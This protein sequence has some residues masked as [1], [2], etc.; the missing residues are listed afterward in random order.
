MPATYN[1]NAIQSTTSTVLY[2]HCEAKSSTRSPFNLVVNPFISE[3]AHW[4]GGSE[5]RERR[6]SDSRFRLQAD[7]ADSRDLSFG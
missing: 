4:L 3:H 6:P 1:N 5:C 2:E 7:L